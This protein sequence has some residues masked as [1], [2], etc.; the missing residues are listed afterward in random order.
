MKT[1]TFVSI[2]I[3]IIVVL[4]ICEG[5]ATDKKVTKKDYR[6]VRGI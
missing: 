1:K 3:L 5:Y 4:I 6:Y 2:L